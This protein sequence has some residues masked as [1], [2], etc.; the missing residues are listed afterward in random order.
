[1]RRV[2][3]LMI[4]TYGIGLAQM[5][6][7]AGRSLAELAQARFTPGSVTVLAGS[8]N[9][10]GGG[11]VAARHLAN[12]GV[13][14]EVVVAGTL[15]PGPL[16]EAQV[17]AA[18]ACGATQT[19]EP[20]SSDLVIDAL[21]G[22]GLTGPLRGRVAE[23]AAWAN[24]LAVPTLSL[25]G[26]SGLDM[27]SGIAGPCTVHAA[28]TMTL[29]LPKQ[30]LLAAPETGELYLADISVPNRLYAELGLEVPV[31]FPSGG[32]RRLRAPDEP[33]EDDAAPERVDLET[34]ELA[35]RS[36]WQAGRLI[37]TGATF[38]TAT[39]IALVVGTVLTAVNL[40]DPILAGQL[41][42]ATGV[43]VVANY[44]IPYVVSSMGVLSRTRVRG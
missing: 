7:N 26:P 33:T 22:Y 19:E 11:L 21:V 28:A 13:R 44:L 39:R 37:A 1:M 27:D 23:L 10:A 34:T 15:R 35:W 5:M 36:W 25:D 17:R 2:D 3:E 18:T 8:G 6:E 31:L 4:S 20:G 42:P 12:H 14:V 16:L 29:A 30:G 41:D 32:L 43:R 40:G 38:A 9:N 24:S